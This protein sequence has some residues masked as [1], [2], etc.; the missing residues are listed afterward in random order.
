[1]LVSGGQQSMDCR[2][3]FLRPPSRPVGILLRE[4]VRF[5]DGLQ[6]E[7]GRRLDDAVGDRRDAQG[8]LFAVRLG[9]PHPFDRSRSVGVVPK[10][11]RQFPEPVRHSRRFDVREIHPVHAG[12]ALIGAALPVGEREDILAVHLVVQEVEPKR[13]FGLRFGM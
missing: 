7:H 11:L 3:R 6:H 10:P 13:G 8:A 12:G 9:Y 2:D 5:K 4:E 1:M